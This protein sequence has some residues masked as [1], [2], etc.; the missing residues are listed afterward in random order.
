MNKGIALILFALATG[1]CAKSD[2]KVY[3]MDRNDPQKSLLHELQQFEE[4]FA[5]PFS[6]TEDFTIKHGI[7]GDYLAFFKSLGKPYY[8]IARSKKDKRVIKHINDQDIEVDQKA[9]EIAAVVCC[10]LR[11]MPTFNGKTKSAWYICDLKVH[12]SYQGQHLPLF[13]VKKIAFWRYMQCSRGFAICMNP[14]TGDPKA[15]SI[16]KKHGP[17][18]VDTQVLNLYNLSAHQMEQHRDM[19]KKI[20]IDHGYMKDH[21]EL[22]YVSTHGAKD[23][24]IT[25]TISQQK[26]PWHLLHIQAGDDMQAPLEDD[27]TYMICAVEGTP[28]D[29]HFKTLLGAPSS[30]AQILS[31]GMK[32]IDFNCLTSNQI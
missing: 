27:A 2:F 15:A 29:T 30:T 22:L 8:Y 5:Y 14:A 1:I 18:N 19:L 7:H 17:W 21:Q 13:M 3:L 32:D 16:F 11:K 31:Y 24:E 20:L 23:Y 12:Q 6:N 10:V 25:D 4:Q 26:R 9:D 28:L